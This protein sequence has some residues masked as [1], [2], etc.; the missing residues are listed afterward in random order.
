[1]ASEHKQTNRYNVPQATLISPHG[2]W[3]TEKKSRFFA[4]ACHCPTPALAREFAARIATKFPD[5]THN[6]FAFVAGP[7]GDT[8]RIGCSDDGEPHGTAGRPMLTALLGSGVGEIC[9]V[10]SRWFG[11]VK[12][13]T[14]GLVRAYRAAVLENLATLP[15]KTF[16]PVLQMEFALPYASID[17]FQRGLPAIEGE[18]LES[19]YQDTARFKVQV[20][21]E[22]SK[23]L[24][25]LAASLG[26]AQVEP[27]K[28][29]NFKIKMER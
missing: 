7:P 26:A 18:V 29:I 8:S 2:V 12:L 20:P 19:C 27:E 23:N 25:D 13:G 15:L 3:I 21:A 22:N 14:G 11:G 10:V 1:M 24:A 16:M 6:C 17:A 9:V 5:A 28:K 4:Q